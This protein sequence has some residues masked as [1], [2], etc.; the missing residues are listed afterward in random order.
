MNL[1]HFKNYLLF[2]QIWPYGSDP[3]S[4]RKSSSLTVND[5]CP[6]YSKLG[7]GVC[8]LEN[9]NAICSYDGG[10]CCPNADLIRNGQCDYVNYNRVC[11]FDGGDCCYE[12]Y[13]TRFVGDGH[14]TFIHNLEMCNYDQGDCCDH[15]RIG[16]GICDDTNNNGICQYDGGDCCFGDKNTSRCSFCNC[17][18][19]FN[20][21][22]I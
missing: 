21:T 2:F 8:N 6:N 11:H 12:D 13:I 7:N 19:V 5:P 16:D 4:T 1:V 20:V 3:Y 10:D 15:S 18:D 22:S 17:I 9:N 14:C